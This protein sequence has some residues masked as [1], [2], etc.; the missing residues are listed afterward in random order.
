M[1]FLV[2][3]MIVTV[4]LGEYLQR[5][6]GLLPRAFALFPDLISLIAAAIVCA[7]L[8]LNRF[9]DVHV[10][11][12]MVLGLLSFNLISGALVNE[13]KPGVVVNG[14][15]QYLVAMPFFFLPLVVNFDDKALQKQLLLIATLCLPQLPLAWMQR[16]ATIARGGVTGDQTFG[17]LMNSAVL[18]IFLCCVTAV[19]VGLYVKKRMRLSTLILF[20]AVTLPATMINETKGTLLLMPLAILTPMILTGDGSA[21]A[22]LRRMMLGLGILTAFAAV[23]IPVYDHLIRERWGYGL[24]EF[25]QRE[26]RVEGY[27]QKGTE[28]GTDENAGRLDS[29]MLPFYAA[30]GDVTRVTFGFGIANLSHSSLGPGFVGEHYERYGTYVGPQVSMLLWETGVFGTILVLVLLFLLFKETLLARRA[31][32]FVGVF[33]TG[34]LGV[35]TVMILCTIYK[36]TM[37]SAALSFLFWFYSGVICAGAMRVR[38]DVASLRPAASRYGRIMNPPKEPAFTSRKSG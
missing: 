29:M 13:L 37:L 31:Q 32:G 18:S 5:E 19:C 16:S 17:T 1:Q 8:P 30:K 14:I 38:R 3:V 6:A 22:T 7:R 4:L 21:S 15:R 35:M 33:A 10:P 25:I 20:L 23:F 9:R 12:M 28:I 24:I 27:L 11:I 36:N 26:N 34:W 2:Y